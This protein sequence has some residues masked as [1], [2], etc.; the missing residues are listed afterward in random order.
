VPEETSKTTPTE[1][2]PIPFF[3]SWK[4]WYAVVLLN[5]VAL[6]VL[7]TILTKVFD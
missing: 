5:L 6:I 3:Q 1:E 4:A 7:F 2:E